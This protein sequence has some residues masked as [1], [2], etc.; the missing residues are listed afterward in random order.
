MRKEL[1]KHKTTIGKYCCHLK[2]WFVVN[3]L[4]I[5]TVECEKCKNYMKDKYI[6]EDDEIKR[7]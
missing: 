6:N 5:D 2:R 3:I 7:I 4:C 1:K